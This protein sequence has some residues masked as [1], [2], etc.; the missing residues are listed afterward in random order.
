MEEKEGIQIFYSSHYVRELKHVPQNI[1]DLVAKRIDLFRFDQF[2]APLHTH[3]LSGKLAG[4][5]AFSV[6]HNYRII[7]RFIDSH[8]V[9]FESIGTHDEVY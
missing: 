8:I 2:A 7:F 3:K 9:F 6:I 1:S 4:K 5:Y